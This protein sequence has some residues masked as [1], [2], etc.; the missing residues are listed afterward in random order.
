[1][2]TG[3]F[4]LLPGF[5][6]TALLDPIP[7]VR[8]QPNRD[9]GVSVQDGHRNSQSNAVSTTDSTATSAATSLMRL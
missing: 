2:H 9:V 5:D 7:T 1:M 8:H 6:A 4:V 3:Q